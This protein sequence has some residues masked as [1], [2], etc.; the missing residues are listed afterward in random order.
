MRPVS[1]VRVLL[2]DD[3]STITML[4]RMLLERMGDF[5]VAEED[6]AARALQTAREFQ[7]DVIFLD[8]S[9]P[10][11]TGCQIAAELQADEE[12]KTIPLAYLTGGL[13]REE[14]STGFFNGLPTLRKPFNPDD[15]ARMIH[16]LTAARMASARAEALPRQA[17]A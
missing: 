15:F 17:A 10:G 2:I 9:L 8:R 4:C 3:D 11:K 6:E 12:L 13:S 5:I 14:T 16:S 7:P 1:P